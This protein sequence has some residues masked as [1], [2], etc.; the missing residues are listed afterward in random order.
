MRGDVYDVLQPKNLTA[1]GGRGAS[2]VPALH[3]LS[4]HP[5]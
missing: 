5:S 4:E 3:C 2:P 1:V